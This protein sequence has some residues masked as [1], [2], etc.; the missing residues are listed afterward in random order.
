MNEKSDE[1]GK[2]A[3]PVD[4]V[5][6]PLPKN[7]VISLDDL[8]QVCGMFDCESGL[9][10]GFGCKATQNTQA[11]G[12]CYS[13]SCPIAFELDDEDEAGGEATGAALCDRSPRP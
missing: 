13:F 10:G 2:V 7:E 8:T 12:C 11:P 4:R 5:V 1:A 6:M 9:N 3:S